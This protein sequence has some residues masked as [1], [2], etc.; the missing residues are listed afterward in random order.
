[1][2]IAPVGVECEENL[3]LR[4]IRA[5]L[6]ERGHRVTQITF[7]AEADTEMAAECLARSGAGLAGVSMVFTCRAAEFAAQGQRSR[8]LGF[9][10]H[11]VAGGILPPSMPR[12]CC[13]TCRRSI[14]S[15]SGN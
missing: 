3:A 8:E 11:L 2:N 9:R 13:A 14:R 5:A 1:M 7:N 12:R 15:L 10:G 4:Y 6:E